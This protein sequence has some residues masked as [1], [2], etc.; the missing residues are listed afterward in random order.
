MCSVAAAAPVALQADL[1]AR[2]TKIGYLALMRR[3][4]ELQLRY[5]FAGACMLCDMLRQD[6]ASVGHRHVRTLMCKRGKRSI[7]S[8]TPRGAMACKRRSVPAAGLGDHATQPRLG[9]HDT[10]CI[11]MKRSFVYLFAVLDWATRRVFS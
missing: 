8:P 9:G 6:G 7:V 1:K 11:P 2:H 3:I 4:D 5:P 10:T